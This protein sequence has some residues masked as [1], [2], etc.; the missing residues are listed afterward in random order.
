[1][2]IFEV[3][4]ELKL[5]QGEITATFLHATLEG[6]ENLFVELPFGFRKKGKMLKFKKTLFGLCW[7]TCALWKYLVEN[8]K[9]V[10]F[11][12]PTLIHVYSLGKGHVHFIC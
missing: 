8:Q 3:L 4:L 5:K 10:E 6:G 7:A 12:S 9:P 1:M 2:L 11:I